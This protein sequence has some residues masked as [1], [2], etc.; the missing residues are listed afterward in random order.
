M[1]LIII[2]RCINPTCQGTHPA[3]DA[4]EGGG[5]G[6]V[7]DAVAP[8]LGEAVLAGPRLQPAPR[9]RHLHVHVGLVARGVVLPQRRQRLLRAALPCKQQ[10]DDAA[11]VTT[12]LPQGYQ[13]TQLFL[14]CKGVP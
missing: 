1:R 9:H 12:R 13:H 8:V 14:Y 4:R 10:A 3:E 2:V 11:R 7:G 5:R 6:A